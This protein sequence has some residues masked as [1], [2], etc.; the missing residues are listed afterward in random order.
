MIDAAAQ[1]HR[2]AREG[3]IPRWLFWVEAKNRTTGLIE[4]AGL[5]TGD[6]NETFLIDGV[7]R[8]YAAASVIGFPSLTFQSGLGVQMQ[9]LSLGPISP[10]VEMLLN[11]YEPRLA[12]VE[13]HLASIHPDTHNLI[14]LERLYKGWIDEAPVKTDPLGGGRVCEISLAGSA[15]LGTKTLPT[16]KSDAAQSVRGG[17]R[18]RR[19]ADVVNSKNYWGENGP[20]VAPVS[21]AAVFGQRTSE[22]DSGT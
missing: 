15:R 12:P 6:Q 13:V 18:F 19:Y 3:L 22:D 8:D 9:S 14:A 5:W 17:D 16:K 1:A 7:S 20:R 2:I 11:G 21:I 4:V 10:E